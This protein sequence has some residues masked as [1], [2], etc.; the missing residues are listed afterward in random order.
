MN[1][2][3]FFDKRLLKNFWQVFSCIGGIVSFILLFLDIPQSCKLITFVVMVIALVI[4][5]FV[6]WRIVTRQ[7]EI[8]LHFGESIVEVYFGDIFQ[9]EEED[10]KIISFNEYFD[11]EMGDNTK[12]ISPGTINGK[13]IE[14][15]KD[16]IP[17]FDKIIAEDEYLNSEMLLE[18]VNERKHG[19][20]NKYKL[21]SLV[22]LSDNYFAVAASK[23]DKDNKANIT[24]RE[25]IGFLL[26]LWSEVDRIYNNRSIVIPVFGSNILRF[27]DGY[28][29]ATS[30]DLLEII[31]WTFKISRIKIAYPSKIKIVV[32]ENK[33]DMYNL[34]KL[35]E[36][37]KNGI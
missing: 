3:S 25:Y 2:V 12:I 26:T 34:Y 8:T 20:K 1:K 17:Q 7:K 35:K 14:M 28:A 15:N 6:V 9:S 37:E 36:L 29:G 32:F 13:F 22:N 21:G 24:M 27:T 31:I 16:K 4:Y 33:S 18:T 10:L 23:F 30:Q 5:Y 11:T 19:K